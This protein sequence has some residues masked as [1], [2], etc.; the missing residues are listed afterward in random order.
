MNGKQIRDIA[1]ELRKQA[2]IL[3]NLLPAPDM[4]QVDY[5]PAFE[6]G[7][8]HIK[9]IN[10]IRYVHRYVKVDAGVMGTIIDTNKELRN[11]NYQWISD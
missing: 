6:L 10:G 1:A 9:Y 11:I 7:T 2:S 5:E 4:N 3:E 8:R